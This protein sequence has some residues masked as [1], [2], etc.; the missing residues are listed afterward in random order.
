MSNLRSPRQLVLFAQAFLLMGGFVA[1]YNFLGFRLAA[2]PF[3]VP[4]HLVSLVFLAYLAGTW[5]SARAGAE[6]DRFGRKPVLLVS[7]AVMA[8][9]VA[10]TLSSSLWVVLVGLVLATIGFFG[11]HA[12][13][14]GWTGRRRAPARLRRPR[15]TTSPTTAGPVPSV[16]SA[17]SPSMR[18]AGPRWQAPCW[19]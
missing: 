7:I 10:M 4:H 1:L 17:A 11:A 18:R 5:A 19:P 3:N 14:S 8:A 15:C 9:G 2:P 6:A 13:A 12:V 16:G